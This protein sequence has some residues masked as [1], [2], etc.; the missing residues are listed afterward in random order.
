MV[1]GAAVCTHSV[2]LPEVDEP[3]RA[4]VEA[5]VRDVVELEAGILDVHPQADVVTYRRV[6]ARAAHS[7][8][9]HTL[10]QVREIRLLATRHGMVLDRSMWCTFWVSVGFGTSAQ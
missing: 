2:I 7:G 3:V 5:V 4:H 9:H 10:D 6:T 1:R 8:Y